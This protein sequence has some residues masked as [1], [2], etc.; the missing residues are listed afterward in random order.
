VI[1]VLRPEFPGLSVVRMAQLLEVPRSLVYRVPVK[2]Q[3]FS[4]VLQAIERLVVC[5]LGYGYRRVHRALALKGLKVGEYRTRKLMREH[6]LLAR[7]A[8]SRGVTRASARERRLANLVKGLKATA[9]NQV[10]VADTT[11][12][13]TQTGPVYLAAILDVYSRKAISWHL[14]RRNDE[15]LV[16]TCLAKALHARKPS[17]G[18]I[19]H[20]DQGST[21]TAQGYARLIRDHGGRQSLSAPGKPRDNAY[22]ES[23]FRTVKL[24]EV[25]RNHYGSFLEA[26]AAL[27]SY[28]KGNYN[29]LRMHSSLGYMSPDQFEAQSNGEAQP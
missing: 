21:Y 12:V 9:P 3:E 6:G 24:E 18:W 14:S 16:S 22:V 11:L 2:A 10:W 20:S 1:R 5:F 8:R 15:A 27:E 13:R 4:D 29:P 26:E 23:F 25:D 19:H 17:S 28:L 7:R